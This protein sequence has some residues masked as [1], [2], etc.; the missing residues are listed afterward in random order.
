MTHAARE[1][2]SDA[3]LALD[4]LQTETDPDRWRVHWAGGV[5][6]LRAVGHV[7]L[8]VD[9]RT[10]TEL[11]KIGDEAHRRWRST[12]PSH[13]VYRDFILEERNNIL[14]EYRSKVHPLA[15][16]PVA[17][18]LT[19]VNPETGEVSYLDQIADFD[20]NLFRPLVE[21]Y[22]EGEDARDVFGE[23]INWWERELTAI[24][25]ELFT[26]LRR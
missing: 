12:D 2:L 6:L 13:A 10:N 7:L 18:R 8:N 1:V 26:R 21:G 17:I 22:G 23:A 16:V 4:M 5:A 24:D 20:E 15:E 19:V 9:Q 25:K 3:R 14:K 11:A